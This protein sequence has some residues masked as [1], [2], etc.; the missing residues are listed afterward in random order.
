MF[1]RYTEDAKRAIF[2]ARWEAQQ[3]SSVYIEPEHILL[4]LTHDADSKANQLFALSPHK[5]IF[6]AQLGVKPSAKSSKA[7]DFPLSNPGKRV[8]AYAAQE[9]DR[10]VSTPIGAE[11]LLLGLLREKQSTVPKTLANAG[12]DLRSARKQI[13]T[14][15]GLPIPDS[16]LDD[17]ETFLMPMR[18]FAAFALLVVALSLLYLIFRLVNS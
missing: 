15:Q 11:H 17:K 18:P 3:S 13:R 5:E 8:L 10:L 14:A 9:A 1:E 4:G 12:I 16:E 2:F 7:S 6:R